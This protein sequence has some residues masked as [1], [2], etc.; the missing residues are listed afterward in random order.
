MMRRSYNLASLLESH[1]GGWGWGVN[2]GHPDLRSLHTWGIL[3]A[4][5]EDHKAT[6][7]PPLRRMSH[8]PNSVL[9]IGKVE[10]TV[11]GRFLTCSPR[12]Y[13][14]FLKKS[15]ALGIDR[16]INLDRVPGSGDPCLKPQLLTRL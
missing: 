16:N 5:R 14:P 11:G 2:M 13:F 3:Q 8:P 1:K 6:P 15:T 10:W 12:S 7:G 9:V 4:F